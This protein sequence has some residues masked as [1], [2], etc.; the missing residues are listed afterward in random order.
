MNV[1]TA[2]VD[3][4][5][6]AACPNC[7]APG[8]GACQACISKLE[9]RPRIATRIVPAEFSPRRV[10]F[11]TWVGL[12][13]SPPIDRFIVAYKDRS[14]KSLIKVLAGCLAVVVDEAAQ[15]IEED[16]WTRAGKTSAKGSEPV[17]VPMPSSDKAL[18]ERGFD[19]LGLVTAQTSK[20]CSLSYAHLLIRTRSPA[21]QVKS[22]KRNRWVAQAGS[23]S[24]KPGGLRVIL[25][26]DVLTTGA[27]IHEGTRALHQ[28]GH[29]VLARACI[30]AV[31]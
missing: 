17:L 21:D 18:R 25:L 1:I 23:M 27:T 22:S 11:Q 26:D 14:M 7:G 29:H 8:W 5:L 6:G 3:L 15:T 28:A 30:A 20:M 10:D 9:I 19:H 13:Y 16:D 24:A 4:L 31:G 12:E 2:A